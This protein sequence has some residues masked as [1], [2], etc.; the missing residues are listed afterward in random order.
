MRKFFTFMEPLLD[1]AGDGGAGGGTGTGSTGAGA[2][3]QQQTGQSGQQGSQGSQA[4]STQQPGQGTQSGASNDGGQP[5][6]GASSGNGQ[7]FDPKDFIPR[8]RFNEVSTKNRELETQL[9]DLNRRLTLA[10]GGDVTDPDTAKANAVK[11]AFFKLPGMGALRKLAELSEDQLEGLLSV[12]QHVNTSRQAELR[13]WERHG[14]Q[15]IDTISERVA[16]A[17]GSESLNEDQKSDLRDNFSSWIRA[18]ARTEL[19]QAVDRYGE[20][21]VQQD[22]RRFSPTI[23]AYE[24]GDAKLLDEFVTRY[25]KNWVEP[26]RRTATARTSTRTRP[27]PDGSGRSAVSTI[28]KPEKFNSLDE[29]LEYAAKLAKERGVVFGR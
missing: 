29:R 17:I 7:Q 25:T 4:S 5:R 11:E 9:Q 10:L 28:Q 15:V 1:E 26:A 22:E 2:S 8:H 18:R 13:Q 23:R 21:A 16:D 20:D 14:N 6:T 19:S 3:G 12:P 27:V 24:D